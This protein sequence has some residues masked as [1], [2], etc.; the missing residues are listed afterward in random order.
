MQQSLLSQLPFHLLV[1]FFRENTRR[2]RSVFFYELAYK[3]VTSFKNLIIEI[4]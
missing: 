3:F 1:N 4:L 2:V